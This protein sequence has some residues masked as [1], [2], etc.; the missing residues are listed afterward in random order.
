M[1]WMNEGMWDRVIRVLVG[2]VLGYVGLMTWPGI[3][4]LVLLVIGVLALITGIVGWCP[5]YT[6]FGA[7]TKKTIGA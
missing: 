2:I 5:V 6:L 1:T 4:S 7:S 3:A